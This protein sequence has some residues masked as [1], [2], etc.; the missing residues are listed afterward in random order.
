[1]HRPDQKRDPPI[2]GCVDGMGAWPMRPR[3]PVPGMV[4]TVRNNNA[5]D[6]GS[7]ALDFG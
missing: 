1:M 4:A 6:V 2:I 3:S 5:E 7:P